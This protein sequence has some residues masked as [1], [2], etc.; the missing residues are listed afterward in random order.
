M[1]SRVFSDSVGVERVIS[2]FQAW[3]TVSQCEEDSIDSALNYFN[4]PEN[5]WGEKS[6]EEIYEEVKI[7]HEQ[8]LNDI[9]GQSKC[10]FARTIQVYSF[11]KIQT[12]N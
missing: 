9:F 10:D 1:A 5:Y 2:N 3:T 7:D 6:Y 8:H 4:Y 12:F 11:F